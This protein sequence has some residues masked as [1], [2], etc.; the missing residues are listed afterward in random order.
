MAPDTQY[1]HPSACD[2]IE[3]FL[4]DGRH[5]HKTQTESKSESLSEKNRVIGSR[6]GCA[7]EA[8]NVDDRATDS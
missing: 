6:D 7:E 2:S 1:R 4:T 8:N 5:K 3:G